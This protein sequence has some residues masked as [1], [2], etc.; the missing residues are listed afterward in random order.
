MQPFQS[1]H[2]LYVIIFQPYHRYGEIYCIR[3]VS[4]FLSPVKSSEHG[5]SVV[6]QPNDLKFGTRVEWANTL[7]RFFHFF[8]I[9]LLNDFIKVFWSS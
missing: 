3:N 4:F 6:P 2:R 9:C 7:G 8:H 1:L 5:I